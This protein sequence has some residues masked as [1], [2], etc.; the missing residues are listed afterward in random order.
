MTSQSKSTIEN[1]KRPAVIRPRKSNIMVFVM[2]ILAYFPGWSVRGTP[3]PWISLVLILNNHF[4]NS[5]FNGTPNII[6]KLFFNFSTGQIMAFLF[7]VFLNER[8]VR[9]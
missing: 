6:E 2:K 4:F 1:L 7:L 8:T 3:M 5:L 9:K